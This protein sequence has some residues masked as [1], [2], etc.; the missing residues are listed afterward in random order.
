MEKNVDA[1]ISPDAKYMMQ[2]D[3]L[4]RHCASLGS[5][6]HRVPARVRLELAIGPELT[7]RL[8]ASLTAHS[9]R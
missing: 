4:L 1:I 6:E 5:A 7:R 3:R 8:L 2:T 9:R